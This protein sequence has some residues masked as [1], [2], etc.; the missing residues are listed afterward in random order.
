MKSDDDENL[1]LRFSPMDITY[2]DSL[3]S[4]LLA[5]FFSR[6]LQGFLYRGVVIWVAARELGGQAL[7]IYHDSLFSL[8]HT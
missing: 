7:A 2:A 6:F 3:M 1:H 8:L 4:C 5:K